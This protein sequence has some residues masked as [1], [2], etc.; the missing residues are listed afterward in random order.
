MATD[1]LPDQSAEPDDIRDLSYEDAKS[2]L[3]RI[4]A[5]LESG[6][7]G[8]EQSMELWQRGERLAAH[9][10]SWLARAEAQIGTREPDA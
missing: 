6:Q 1:P 10:E 8:L 7:V 2:E 5:Q 4:V 9:C 3:T